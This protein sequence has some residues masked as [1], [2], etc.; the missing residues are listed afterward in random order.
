MAEQIT[1]E[2]EN[3]PTFRTRE[4]VIATPKEARSDT[5]LQKVREERSRQ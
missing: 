3:G 1:A 4:R 5:I 2:E